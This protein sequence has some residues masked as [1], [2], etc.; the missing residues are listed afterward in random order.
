MKIREGME[1][2]YA[3][4]AASQNKTAEG[5]TLVRFIET[6]SGMMECTVDH[7]AENIPEAASL[8]VQA[9]AANAGLTEDCAVIEGAVKLL[10]CWSYGR[11]LRE[12]YLY[13]P[14]EILRSDPD[15]ALELFYVSQELRDA[16]PAIAEAY[17]CILETSPDLLEAH[18]IVASCKLEHDAPTL[19][20]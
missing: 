8:T 20:L 14:P 4:F 6:W 15:T 17:P 13:H 10:E 2:R 18:R 5:Q 19:S 12:W 16:V 3:E 9:A 7:G 1:Q 11:G